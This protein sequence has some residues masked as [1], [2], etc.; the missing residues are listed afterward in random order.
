[1]TDLITLYTPEL[2]KAFAAL[3]ALLFGA[4]IL[5]AIASINRRNALTEAQDAKQAAMDMLKQATDKAKKVQAE[6]DTWKRTAKEV[7]ADRDNLSQQL[8]ESFDARQRVLDMAKEILA[9]RDQLKSE[10]ATLYFRNAKGQIEPITPKE[11]KPH[12]LKHGMTVKD[13]SAYQAK[14]I[15]AAARRA[16]MVLEDLCG[17][18]PLSLI[19]FSDS[20]TNLVGLDT[21]LLI[22]HQINESQIISAS[23]FLR[24][25]KGEI[26]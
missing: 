17:D 19:V 8:S 24:R 13:P 5:Q 15:F 22:A 7:E 20:K 14:R 1:M 10:R 6:R 18:D 25:I 4:N 21:V 2:L 3:T 26:E 11:R 9:E 12:T 23:E 16:G